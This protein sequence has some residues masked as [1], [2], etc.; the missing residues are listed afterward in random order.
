MI[1]KIGLRKFLK[2]NIL[3]INITY[4]GKVM[5][6]KKDIKRVYVICPP[7]FKTGGTELAHQL[8]HSLN[9][10]SIKAKIAYN[11]KKNKIYGKEEIVDDFKK[12]VDEF[13]WLEDIVDEENTLIVFP[14]L[15]LHFESRFKKADKIVWWLSVDN[16]LNF[17]SL[18]S[19]ITSN[20]GE[21]K[22]KILIRYF[23]KGYFKYTKNNISKYF[24][25]HIVQSEYAKEF[26]LEN[27]IKSRFLSDYIS[28]EYLNLTDYNYK[29]KKDIVV[30]N[31]KKGAAFTQE[32]IRSYP[33]LNWVAIQNLT[34]DGVRDLLLSAKV[35]I[36]FGNHPGK[37]RIPRE[38]AMA[39]CCVITDRKGSAAFFE[40]V[41]ISAE[42]KF[43]DNSENLSDIYK[44]IVSC[45]NSYEQESFKFEEYRNY[46][47]GEKSKFEEDVL[48]I[49]VL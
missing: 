10:N 44:K 14:E 21:Y 43:E 49:F 48:K 8:V 1:L 4:R 38:A 32:L 28:D 13:I 17:Y 47:R 18:K 20:T 26:L 31:P 24:P 29:H 33:E 45:I 37:D 35:Y 23:I 6:G 12:Y 34:T 16:Y 30:Y 19:Q 46:I 39:G 40:D 15:A 3:N 22:I 36:D 27:G 7:Y 41:P 42:F 5:N 11:G 9:E 2:L 25:N